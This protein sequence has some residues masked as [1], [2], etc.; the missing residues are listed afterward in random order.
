MAT[1]RRSTGGAGD[2]RQVEVLARVA[3][4]AT[5]DL[6]LGPMLQRVTDALAEMFDW[7]FV[8]LVRVDRDLSMTI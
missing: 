1:R 5:E 4:L 7:E 2:E 8:A 3:R 6:E